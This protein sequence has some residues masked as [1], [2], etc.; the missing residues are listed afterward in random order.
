MEKAREVK[1]EIMNTAPVALSPKMAMSR[2][3]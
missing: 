2:I 3:P 1:R